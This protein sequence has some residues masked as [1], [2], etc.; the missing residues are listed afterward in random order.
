MLN[1]IPFEKLVDLLASANGSEDSPCDE[2]YQVMKDGIR[3]DLR[4][5]FF[6]PFENEVWIVEVPVIVKNG[7]N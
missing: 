7:E 5:S 3:K 6:G 1:P 4:T 2:S